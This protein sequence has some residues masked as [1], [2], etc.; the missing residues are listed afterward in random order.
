MPRDSL[1]A[2]MLPRQLIWEELTP[3]HKKY[4][5]VLGLSKNKLLQSEVDLYLGVPTS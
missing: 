2:S 3:H 4:E 5:T 1:V